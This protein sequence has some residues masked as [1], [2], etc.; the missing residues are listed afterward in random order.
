MFR[1]VPDADRRFIERLCDFD[2]DGAAEGL[3]EDVRL[4]IG[5]QCHAVGKMRV[6]A[7]MVRA[8]GS[9]YSVRCEP[10]V[11]WIN[12]NV[13]IIEA[14]VK[15]ERLDRAMVAFPLTVVIRF[16]DHVISDIRLLTYEPALTGWFP[17]LR[18]R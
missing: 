7:A 15:C 13:A 2:V 16:R 3:S 4:T 8:L 6:R 5:G 17:A 9:V 12:R 1:R 14:D 11:A 10:A 18:S